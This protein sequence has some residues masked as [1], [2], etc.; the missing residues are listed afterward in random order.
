MVPLLL[1]WCELMGGESEKGKTE[2]FEMEWEGVKLVFEREIMGRAPVFASITTSRT[3]NLSS[4]SLSN[5]LSKG[6]IVVGINW[7]FDESYQRTD[8]WWQLWH[9]GSIVTSWVRK[10]ERL[11]ERESNGKYG[12]RGQW[13]SDDWK[14]SREVDTFVAKV[15]F[16]SIIIIMIFYPGKVCPR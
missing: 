14:A 7:K 3:N 11:K 8:T 9:S 10:W 5:V 2:G 4:S 1:L 15:E 6:W 12:W 13:Q 16:W